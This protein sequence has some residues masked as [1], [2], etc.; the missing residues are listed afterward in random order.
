[1]RSLPRSR[2]MNAQWITTPMMNIAGTVISSPTNR[3]MCALV[4]SE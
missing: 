1:M 4:Y 2:R 3:S